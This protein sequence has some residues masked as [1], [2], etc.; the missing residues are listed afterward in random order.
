ML[1]EITTQIA[2][3]VATVVVTLVGGFATWAL[4]ALKNK[5]NIDVSDAQRDALH[6]ALDTGLR[7]A[8]IDAI[9]SLPAGKGVESISLPIVVQNAAQVVRSTNPKGTAKITQPVLHDLVASK[10]PSV[11]AQLG[12]T[13]ATAVAS[14]N[15]IIAAAMPIVMP[16]VEKTLGKL[17]LK[18]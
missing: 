3:I 1:H 2:P 9:S 16:Q 12:L 8:I 13:A 11:L 14:T 4:N 5:W 17:I 6:K 7:T 10:L 15:P 18:G